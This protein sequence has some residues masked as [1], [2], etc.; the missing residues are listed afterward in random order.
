[1][2]KIQKLILATFL[3]FLF[4]PGNLQGQVV[5]EKSRDKVI[6]SGKSYYIHTVKKGETAYSISKAYEI[7]PQELTK[8]NPAVADGLKVGQSLKIPVVDNVQK[9]K[10]QKQ[11]TKLT[12]DETK[13]IYHKLSA[14][15]T[16]F[17]LSNKNACAS[18]VFFAKR[19]SWLSVIL[20]ISAIAAFAGLMKRKLG[21]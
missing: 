5:V 4:F 19:Q 11:V 18:F 14:G 13:F 21:N 6:I 2:I 9:P 12:R 10:N 17:A 8:E 1:M 16:V 3:T 15:E 7:T 20:I